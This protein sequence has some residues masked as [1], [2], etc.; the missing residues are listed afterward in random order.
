M[1]GMKEKITSSVWK[2]KHLRGE[3]IMFKKNI[4]IVGLLAALAIMFAG[5]VDAFVE[6]NSGVE[7]VVFDLQETI[8]DLEPQGFWTDDD[9]TPVFKDTPFMMCGGPANGEYSLIKEG[10]VNKVK[11]EKMGPTW[12]V[13]FDIYHAAKK[14][15][16]IGANFK[17]GDVVTIKGTASAD[18][19]IADTDGKSKR[20]GDVDLGKTFDATFTLSAADVA[21]I[22]SANPQSL[23]IHFKDGNGTERK[24]TIIIEQ[25]TVTGIRKAGDEEKAIDYDTVEGK[26]NYVVPDIAYAAGG[27]TTYYVDLNKTRYSDITTQLPA[28]VITGPTKAGVT[29]AFKNGKLTITF[30]KNGQ[31]VY[32][33][34]DDTLLRIVKSAR[35]EQNYKVE[36]I[37]D[38]TLSTDTV[39]NAYRGDWTNGTGGNWNIS[40]STFSVSTSAQVS[41]PWELSINGGN[42]RTVNDLQGI[43]LQARPVNNIGSAIA[44]G[45]Y[46][47]TIKSIAIRFTPP[48]TAATVTSVTSL[49]FVLNQ[50]R[51]G[52]TADKTISGTGF[53][54]VV[55]WTPALPG[56]GKFDKSE[57]YRAEVTITPNLGYSIAVGATG[58]VTYNPSA[59]GVA[60]SITSVY[61]AATKTVITADFPRTK[62]Y[63]ELSPG[64]IYKLS[65]SGVLDLTDNKFGNF[66]KDIQSPLENAGGT[67]KYGF[68]NSTDNG[69]TVSPTGA[70]GVV[71]TGVD[72]NWKGVTILLSAID[73]G[74]E[75]NLYKVSVVVTGKVLAVKDGTSGGKMRISS[76]A[77]DYSTL[78]EDTANKDVGGTFTLTYTEIRANQTANGPLRISNDDTNITSFIITDVTVTNNGPR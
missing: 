2:K 60:A 43:V 65:T 73:A 55:K 15:A 61:S 47:L 74:I 51:A 76:G 66:G 29:P 54:G 24:G 49:A 63:N 14:D 62:M 70:R 59:G 44:G 18:G 4:W 3:Q 57:T 1:M 27:V 34:L 40:N 33:P 56:N 69:D 20:L 11:V 31:G 8:K 16:C 17:A 58:S 53:T 41:D 10:G 64:Q 12:G 45:P 75:P 46:T 36:A 42:G 72:A 38:G 26:G 25:I 67:S 32:F 5:C 9:W 13:G 48:G 19:L 30:D 28:A 37:F 35:V 6:D 7:T 21:N 39:T 77:G 22:K 52:A 50:P 23:R 78:I 68:D 71:V